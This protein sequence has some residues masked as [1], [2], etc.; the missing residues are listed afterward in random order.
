LGGIPGQPGDNC[1]PLG[2]A[3][4]VQEPG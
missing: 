3:L 4:I 1:E 2:N